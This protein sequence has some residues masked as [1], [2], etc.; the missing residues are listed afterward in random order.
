MIC[1]GISLHWQADII[2]MVSAL[3][4]FEE[5]EQRESQVE[6]LHAAANWLSKLPS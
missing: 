5:R 4:E 3:S 2:S 6:R 1:K